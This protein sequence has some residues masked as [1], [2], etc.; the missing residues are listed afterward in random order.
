MLKNYL[1]LS[2]GI[3]LVASVSAWRSAQ[4]GVSYADPVGGWRYSYEADAFIAGTV[5]DSCVGGSCPDGYGLKSSTPDSLDGTWLHNQGDKWDGSAPGDPLGDYHAPPAD[6]VGNPRSG[7]Q[8]IAPGGAG[9]FNDSGVSF[10]RVQDPGNPEDTNYADM[11]YNGYVQENVADP[12]GPSKPMNSNRRVYFGHAMFQDGTITD[13]LILTNTDVTLSFRARIPGMDQASGLDDIYQ[14]DVDMDGDLNVTPWF[15]DAPHGR[16]APM[17]NGRGTINVVQ[18]APNN[19]DTSVGFSLVNSDDITA[20]CGSSGGSLC[21]GTGS[22]GLIMNNL[23]GN[24]PGNVDSESSGML[25]ILEMDDEDLNEWHEF[26]IT[27]QNNGPLDGNIEV[28]VYMDGDVSDPSTFQVTLSGANNAVYSQDNDPF[29]EFGFSFN[30]EFG[31]IDIDFLSYAFGVIA[32]T[33]NPM[34]PPGDY[35]D[36]GTVDAADYVQWRK[37]VGTSNSLPNDNGI[38]GIIGDAHYNLWRSNFGAMGPGSASALTASAVPEPASIVVFGLAA[39]GMGRL[40]LRRK[41]MV[42]TP[43][44][45]TT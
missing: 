5:D 14:Q 2:G 8:G 18:N 6:P 27:M 42:P 26:W 39:L 30:Q 25:N 4:A 36:D 40:R 21:T 20:F 32:P 29:L 13:E 10:I 22:G 12:T 45:Q 9:I 15:E 33:S 23:A 16:G 11:L 24:T 35:N 17:V 41:L 28:K 37:N 34:G 1:I 44:R 19:D 43:R 38:G 3:C 7:N 31:S